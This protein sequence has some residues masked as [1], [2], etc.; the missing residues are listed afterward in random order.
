MTTRFALVGTGRIA[1]TQPKAI[2]ASPD[3]ERM[4]ITFIAER[5]ASS[6]MENLH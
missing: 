3:P 4:A 2:A 5:L 6:M 1:K